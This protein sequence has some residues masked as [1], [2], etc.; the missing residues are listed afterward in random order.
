MKPFAQ[1]FIDARAVGTP[2]V[3]VRTF[4]PASTV[5]NVRKSLDAQH[6]KDNGY[7][8]SENTPLVS[9][10]SIHGLKGL[11]TGTEKEPGLGTKALL[12]MKTLSALPLQ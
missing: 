8:D 7:N 6:M 5:R 12:D 10:D 4:D 3:A 2:C 11:N 1:L 9:W